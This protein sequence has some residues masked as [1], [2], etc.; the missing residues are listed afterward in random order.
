MAGADLLLSMA[1]GA[2][3]SWASYSVV[4][5]V[6]SK[7]QISTLR[8]VAWGLWALSP[9]CLA[10]AHFLLLALNTR[11]KNKMPCAQL[12]T[13]NAMQKHIITPS[14]SASR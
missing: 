7:R 11:Q 1:A 8:A 6:V 2:A 12:T 14:K 10:Y 5:H 3:L 9:W 4:A 13:Q